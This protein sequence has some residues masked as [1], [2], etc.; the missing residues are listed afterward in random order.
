MTTPPTP[1]PSPTEEES[2][3]D[4]AAPPPEE[5]CKTWEQPAA[6]SFHQKSSESVDLQT[7]N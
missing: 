6:I 1:P 5:Q 7:V 2:F 3:E 4:A